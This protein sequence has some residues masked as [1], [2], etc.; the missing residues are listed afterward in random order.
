VTVLAIASGEWPNRQ[1]ESESESD[2]SDVELEIETGSG[3]YEAE[4]HHEKNVKN[5]LK[6]PTEDQ[7]S[8]SRRSEAEELFESV[9]ETI[10]SLFRMSIIIR[11]ASPRDRFANAMSDRD[12]PFA[13]TSPSTTCRENS[14]C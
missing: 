1:Y 4:C 7:G 12:S 3:G 8:N 14:A 9:K 5:R 2:D 13:R 6:P 11:K 10:T